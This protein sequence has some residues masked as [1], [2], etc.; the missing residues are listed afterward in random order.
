MSDLLYPMVRRYVHSACWAILPSKLAEITELLAIKSTGGHIS[1]DEI[2]AQISAAADRQS[3]QPT[4]GVAV[5]PIVGT[6]AHRMDMLAESSG[7]TSVQSMT[8]QFRAFVADPSISAIVLDVDSPGGN[9][10]GIDEFATE[11]YRARGAKPIVAVANTMA[12]SAAYW[13]ASSASELVATPS[14]SIGSIGVIAAHEDASALYEKMGVKMSLV[15][16]GKYKAENNPFEPMTTDGQAAIQKRVDEVY[17]TFTRTVARNRSAPVDSVRNGFGEGRV[18]GAKEAVSL[19]M[20]DR[21]AT[22]D[23]VISGLLSQT[24]QS[25]SGTNANA[26]RV[27]VSYAEHG[28]R[29][30]ADLA[31]F[32]EATRDRIDY[33]RNDPGREPLNPTQRVRLQ[34]VYDQVIE[35]EPLILALLHETEPNARLAQREMLSLSHRLSGVDLA[36]AGLID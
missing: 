12:A 23:D 3:A 32:V 16:A 7:G 30:A 13:L 24:D 14:A 18:V 35:A 17:Q 29:V 34:A 15:T 11:I 8:Q 28:Q 25:S 36:L 9:A 27:A 4:A 6:I 10:A 2:R 5:L 33:R 1:P 21:I 31:L 19:G 20:A 22:I 26:G